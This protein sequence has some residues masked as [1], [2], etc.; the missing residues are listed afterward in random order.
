[1][2]SI[3]ITGC[4]SGFGRAIALSFLDRGWDVIATMRHPQPD[5]FGQHE[6]LKLL[7]LDVTDAQSIVAAVAAAGPIDVLVNNAGVGL[8][9]VLEGVAM[10]QAREVFETNVIGAMA[11]A[12]AVMPQMRTRRAGLIVNIGSSVTLKPLP[13]LSVYSASK[14]AL[15]AFSESLAL[16]A[17]LFDVRV[18]VVLPGASP[19]TQ[20]GKN[21]VA[22]MGLEIPE[23]YRDFVHDYLAKLRGSAEVTTM[24][25]VVDAVW[26]AVSDEHAPMRLVAGADARALVEAGGA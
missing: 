3:F 5:L 10:E 13:A 11:M 1:M 23:P 8:L 20:F 15:N 18:R 19:E 6:R 16:E 24:Q 4:S 2:P 26:R 14:A 22:R 12:R 7:A 25:D 17:A 21:A 9:N